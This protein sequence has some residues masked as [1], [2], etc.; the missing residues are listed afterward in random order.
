MRLQS[1][2]CVVTG[3]IG[4]RTAGKSWSEQQAM[5]QALRTAFA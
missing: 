4:R 1:K 2:V 3:G 5:L